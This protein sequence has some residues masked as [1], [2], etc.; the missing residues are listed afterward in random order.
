MLI[1]SLDQVQ[2]CVTQCFKW[3]CVPAVV[4]GSHML[5]FLLE[6]TLLVTDDYRSCVI[7][8]SAEDS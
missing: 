8:R 1:V 5:Q 4:C 7:Q 2:H 6:S 3:R